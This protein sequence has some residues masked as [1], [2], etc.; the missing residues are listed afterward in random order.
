MRV[1]SQD[2]PFIN[3]ELK[4]IS[5]RKQREYVKKGKSAKYKKLEADFTM[6]YK[7]AA[8]R[9]IRTKVDDLKDAQPGKAFSVLKAMGAQPGDCTDDQTFS[10]PGHLELGLSDQQC[11][12]KNR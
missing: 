7:A 12:E 3:K 2:K 11:A 9:F 6:K 4:D 1:G 10:L 8:K 5:R